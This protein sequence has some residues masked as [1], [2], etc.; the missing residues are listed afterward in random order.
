MK[1]ALLGL[2]ICIG[3][4]WT[5]AT[6]A[7][8]TAIPG[9]P[10]VI[11]KVRVQLSDLL[12]EARAFEII[13]RLAAENIGIVA[14]GKTTQ[15]VPSSGDFDGT[16]TVPINTLNHDRSLQDLAKAIRYQCVLTYFFSDGGVRSNPHIM[17]DA[18]QRSAKP[19]AQARFDTP[20]K[21]IVEG[22]YPIAQRAGPNLQ[23]Q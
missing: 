10:T 16:V 2:T 7:E 21:V 22:A 14:T 15:A 9:P 12:P 17:L 23:A 18:A 13:C 3:L 20:F 11:F 8:E 5:T 1:K 4:V 6:S 19:W